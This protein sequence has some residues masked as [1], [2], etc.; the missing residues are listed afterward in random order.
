MYDRR[1]AYERSLFIE[2]APR[3]WLILGLVAL[4]ATIFLA[5]LVMLLV[6]N[7]KFDDP[8]RYPTVAPGTCTPFC[9]APESP[10]VTQPAPPAQYP[11]PGR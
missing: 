1:G 4:G 6:S 10:G 11:M 5:F 3:G 2:V 9:Y 8:S 7:D